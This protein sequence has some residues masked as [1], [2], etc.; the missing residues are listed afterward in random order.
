VRGARTIIVRARARDGLLKIGASGIVWHCHGFKKD[1][2]TG[3]LRGAH[4]RARFTPLIAAREA[5]FRPSLTNVYVDEGET[6]DAA[7]EGEPVGYGAREMSI[8]LTF[9][10]F[11]ADSGL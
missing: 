2:R 9:E 7:A 8:P 1:R 5:A 6:N 4:G 10:S 11:E 3:P